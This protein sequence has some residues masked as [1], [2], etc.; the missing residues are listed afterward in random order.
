MTRASWVR[1]GPHPMAAI[2]V[3]RIQTER[4]RENDM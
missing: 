1:A 4:Y 2:L 3:C